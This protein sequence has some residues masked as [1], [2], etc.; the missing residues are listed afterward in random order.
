MKY[1]S[2][3]Y[4][5]RNDEYIPGS[6][7]RFQT[8]LNML[9]YLVKKCGSG[10]DMEVIVVEW[11]PLSNRARLK[12]AI[13]WPNNIDC[14]IIV[15]P[16]EIHNSLPSTK[17]DA[18]NC[19]TIPFYEFI[20]KNV[21]MRR[22]DSEFVLCTNIDI[23]L[24][25]S[26]MKFLV[27]KTLS[28]N[29]FYRIDRDDVTKNIN[30]SWNFKKQLRFCEENLDPKMKE[31]NKICRKR[32]VHTKASGDF[33]LAPQW[34]FEKS[35]GYPEMKTGGAAIDRFGLYC[36]RTVCQQVILDAPMKIYHQL[37][38]DREKIFLNKNDNSGI[39]YE[40]KH[41]TYHNKNTKKW[42]SECF[43]RMERRGI[44]LNMN[45][46]DWGL[47]KYKLEQINV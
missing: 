47:M 24:N 27:S 41:S 13:R 32:Y 33:L 4:A 26:L 22:A 38:M 42:F 8:T 7:E 10:Q 23:L 21:G 46:P 11:N 45:P 6:L 2:I 9:S 3:I 14:R 40:I 36:M 39:K 16:P 12:D 25:K 17:W 19:K 31:K 37:H 18:E 35:R 1:L 15:V 29:R 5:T 30:V 28:H 20:A 44:N 43:E 34:A